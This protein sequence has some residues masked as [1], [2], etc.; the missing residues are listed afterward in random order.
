MWSDCFLHISYVLTVKCISTQLISFWTLCREI[1]SQ[2][3]TC[4]M[5]TKKLWHLLNGDSGWVGN[6]YPTTLL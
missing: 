2:G 5:N 1:V 6:E 3:G 4:A